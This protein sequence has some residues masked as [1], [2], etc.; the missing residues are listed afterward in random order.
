MTIRLTKTTLFSR[1]MLVDRNNAVDFMIEVPMDVIV[2]GKY[3][4]LDHVGLKL[5]GRVL[6]LVECDV[7]IASGEAHITGTL[8]YDY[9]E[10]CNALRNEI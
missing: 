10:E 7:K 8:H 5:F 1:N 3:P 2:K 9:V 4:I 6:A